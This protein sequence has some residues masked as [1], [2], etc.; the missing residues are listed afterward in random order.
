[1][2]IIDYFNSFAP[3]TPLC[4]YNTDPPSVNNISKTVKINI[5]RLDKNVF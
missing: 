1:M 3:G 5:D 2:I 4:G